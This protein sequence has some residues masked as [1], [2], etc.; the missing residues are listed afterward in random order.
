MLFDLKDKIQ[1]SYINPYRLKIS[2]LPRFSFREKLWRK[3]MFS[4]IYPDINLLRR[5][6]LSLR[7]NF[8]SDLFGS[9]FLWFFGLIFLLAIANFPLSISVAIAAVWQ[10]KALPLGIWLQLLDD[11][12]SK[13]DRRLNLFL[14]LFEEVWRDH[15]CVLGFKEKWTGESFNADVKDSMLRR[16]ELEVCD[17][18]E[19][20]S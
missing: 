11:P 15:G 13:N 18:T 7:D 1:V 3:K 8:G 17:T 16:F 9:L 6:L 12:N 10:D 14:F 20:I 2:L 5:A 19:A 4:R